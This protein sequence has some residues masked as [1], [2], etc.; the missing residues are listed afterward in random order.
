[1]EWS[2]RSGMLPQMEHGPYVI[3]LEIFG[4]KSLNFAFYENI[5]FTQF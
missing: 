2:K 3:L 4:E 1:V 5:L